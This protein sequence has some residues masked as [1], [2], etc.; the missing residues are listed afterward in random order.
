MICEYLNDKYN[1]NLFGKTLEEKAETR[2]WLRRI[3]FNLEVG[4]LNLF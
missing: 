4:C 1:G 2:M 3:D